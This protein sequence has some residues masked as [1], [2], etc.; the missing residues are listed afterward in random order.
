MKGQR[1]HVND[2]KHER[3]HELHGE[4]IHNP[5]VHHEEGDLNVTPVYKFL[6]WLGIGMVMIYFLVYGI[7]KWNDARMEKQSAVVS[8]IPKAKSEQL[9]PEPRLQLAPGHGEHP[10]DE[11]IMYRDSVMHALETYA[12]INK[13]TGTVRIPIDRAKEVLLQKG[14]PTRA[15]AGETP[16]M[17]PAFTSSGRTMIARDQRVPGGT[18]T[19]T[20]GNLNVRDRSHL[21]EGGE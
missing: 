16:G 10:L 4:G 8:H 3:S 19:V 1:S 5:G 9:P 12:M 14:L 18:F 13:A 21:E 2:P 15:Q 7:M 17:I 20:G 11:G 6:L